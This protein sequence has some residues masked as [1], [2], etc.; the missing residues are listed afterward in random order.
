MRL[1]EIDRLIAV[2]ADHGRAR[3]GC[4]P[5]CPDDSLTREEVFNFISPS[6]ENPKSLS[7]LSDSAQGSVYKKC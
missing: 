3:A 5:Q 1:V 4:L 7:A 6:R 2:H